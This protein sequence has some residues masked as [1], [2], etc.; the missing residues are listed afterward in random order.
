[1]DAAQKQVMGTALLIQKMPGKN[2]SVID[3]TYGINKAI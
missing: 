2:A 1:M 3:S